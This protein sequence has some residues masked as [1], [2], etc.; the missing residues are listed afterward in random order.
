MK[1]HGLMIAIS[2]FLSSAFAAVTE[3]PLIVHERAGLDTVRPVTGGVP[4][5]EGAAPEGASFGLRNSAGEIVPVQTEVLGRWK[6]NSARWVLLDFQA[7]PSPNASEAYTLTW[8]A[9]AAE[10]ATPS[11]DAPAPTIAASENAVLT[12]GGQ[13][14]VLLRLTN[15][16]GQAC[17]AVVASVE[18]LADTGSMRATYAVRGAFHDPAGKRMF[19]FR[20]NAS[21]FAGLPYVRLEP[22]IVVDASEGVMQQ[23][24]GLQLTLRPHTAPTQG[25]LGGAPGWSG[26]I[27]TPVRLFQRDDEHYEIQQGGT[28]AEPSITGSKSPGWAEMQDGPGKVAVALRSF[29]QQW[30]KAMAVS[31]EGLSVGLLPAFEAGD[32]DHM[33]PWYKHQY[34]FEGN[35]YRLRTGQARRWEVWV[36]LSGNG[37]ALA[38]A[39]DAP[40]VVTPD[41]AQGIASDVWGAI[42]PAGTPEMAAYDAWADNLFEGYQSSIAAQRDYG[43]MN[44]GDWF[45]EREVNW[46]NHEYD[47]TYQFLVQFARTGDPKYFYA[48]DAAARHSSEVDTVH[49][50]NDDLN[51]HFRPS[52]AFPARPGLVHQHTVGHVSGFYPEETIRA[53]FV[54]RGIGNSDKP[55][56]CLDPFN[57]GHIWTQGMTRHYFLTGDPFLRETVEMIGANLAQLVEDREYK[58][59]GHSHCGR[60]TGWSLIALSGAYEISLNPRYLAAMKTLVD[61]ALA[62]QDPVC[63]GWLYSLPRGHCNCEKAKHVGMA[64]FITAVLVNGISQYYAL[65]EDERIPDAVNRAVTFLDRDTW[66]EEWQDWRYTSCPASGPIKQMGVIVMAHVNAIRMQED[67]E[68]RRILQIAWDKKFARLSGVVPSGLGQGKAFSTTLYGCPEAVGL[69]AGKGAIAPAP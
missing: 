64:G 5:P 40:L 42:S 17:T 20:L 34:L 41:P 48:A 9:E 68:Q 21:T 47:T 12:I 26:A 46:G 24:G 59:M 54:E 57:L 8:A 32:F 31:P 65:T 15:G 62:E 45:G 23:L 49:F 1:L 18:P 3:L 58:F 53:L 6:D 27:T 7:S 29:W 50:V 2:L 55:Y 63:G 44:W 67:P 28:D 51:T 39:A 14:D 22:T 60:T 66:H 30:P 25:R 37:A 13:V 16:G 4:L 19:Q 69:L 56:L 11:P 43:T 61:D 35:N 33:E 38:K 52:A 36:D 10:I